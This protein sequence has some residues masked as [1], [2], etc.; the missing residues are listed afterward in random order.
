MNYKSLL[1]LLFLI[2]MSC[3]QTNTISEKQTITVSG[4]I[5]NWSKNEQAVKGM[6]FS[7]NDFVSSEYMKYKIKI[8]KNGTFQTSIPTD[9]AQN[10]YLSTPYCFFYLFA[11][12]GSELF[13]EIDAV[14][15]E[16]ASE[17]ALLFQDDFAE[18][19][20]Q[21]NNFILLYKEWKGD[22][23]DIIEENITKLNG[24]N[25]K[26]FRLERYKQDQEYVSNYLKNNEMNAEARKWVNLGIKY[27][28][29]NDLMRYRWSHPL[30]NKLSLAVFELPDS[31]FDFF[32]EFELDNKDAV[33]NSNYNSY[34]QEYVKYLEQTKMGNGRQQAYSDM[35][36]FLLKKGK[37]VEGEDAFLNKIKKITPE[38]F[39]KTDGVHL[40][41]ITQ[42]NEELI[43]TGFVTELY[44]NYIDYMFNN[45][46]GYTKDACISRFFYSNIELKENIDLIKPFIEH[47]KQE[48]KSDFLKKRVLAKFTEVEKLLA[49]LTPPEGANLLVFPHESTNNIFETFLSK[50]KGKVVYIDFWAPW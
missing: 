12:P 31:Y 19:N 22:F 3:M 44:N 23:G 25:Y 4:K 45:L 17:K 35:V 11:E 29:A 16:K 8:E 20:R 48:V 49:D 33:I 28:C 38:Q 5:I 36:E 14:K 42:R 15:L 18:I 2:L 27:Q 10:F 13:V 50:Y 40:Q 24:E 32:D 26:A 37:L 39:S 21:I 47:Y 41:T 46:V 30:K 34:L 9:H 1:G 43:K 6:Y 7:I